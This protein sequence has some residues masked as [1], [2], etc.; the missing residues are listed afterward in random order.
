LLH[1]FLA[2]NLLLAG[3]GAA[4]A[5]LSAWVLVRAFVV[6][7]PFNLF[8]SA[9]IRL[10]VSVL[11]F[12]L[13]VAFA[14]VLIFTLA[15]LVTASRL[16]V[17]DALKSAG[18][19]SGTGSGRQRTRSLLVIAE[20]ALSVT[21]LVSAVLLIQSLA[22]LRGEQLGFR[23]Q[24]VLTFHTPLAADQRRSGAT[25]HA[26]ESTLR[27]H[28][29]SVPGI[30]T[31]AAINVLP[32]DGWWNI[33]TQ[34]EGRTE[35]SI[36]G[37]EIRQVTPA[38]FEA[39]GIPIRAGRPIHDNDTAAA[40]PIALI[41]EALARAWWPGGNPV[42][43]RL[44]VGRFQGRDFPEIQDA[45]REIIGI[46]ADTKTA[47]LKS[48]AWPTVYI[49]MVQAPPGLARLGNIAWVLRAD[50]SA[51]LAVQ[52]RRAVGEIL[53]TQRILRLRTMEKV[54]AATT[55]DSL[56]DAWLF[57][58]LAAVALGLTAVGVYGLL[59]F[60]VAQRRHEIGTRMALG[61]SRANVL[62]MVL[63]QGLLLTAIG[64]VIGLAAALA[65]G[66]YLATL[67]F[68]VKPNDPL[69]FAAVAA[70]LLAV[71]LLASLL[72]ARR[73]TR[74]DPMVALRYE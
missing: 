3:L 66:R 41:N 19:V 27:E 42:G 38:Y 35:H 6:F 58:T 24:G 56:F 37:M 26:F 43:D 63:Q 15:P 13:A 59:A 65:L 44:I 69:S 70:L 52:V 51:G 8:F 25:V 36:G 68:G 48:P 64:L 30:R 22:R 4:A 14:T 1:Q 55:A 23:P 31:V 18:R 47:F 71:G 32:L 46:V 72:P 12:T 21:L 16:D 67:L 33:P 10:D 17:H 34:H 20:V 62:R 74:V 50:L 54:V 40:P 73:A 28:L 49:P 57:G 39:M 61:A 45:P 5:L 11:L 7:V 9:P 53:P 60:S 2:E 29:R